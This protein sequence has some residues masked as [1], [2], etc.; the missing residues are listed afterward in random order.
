MAATPF[1]LTSNDDLASDT[2]LQHFSHD[3]KN[4]SNLL[5]ESLFGAEEEQVSL[6]T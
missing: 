4:E 3:D 2:M 1:Q 5:Q 6:H